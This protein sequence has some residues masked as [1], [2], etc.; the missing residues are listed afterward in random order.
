MELRWIKGRRMRAG[1]PGPPLIP[2]RAAAHVF[3]RADRRPAQ[4]PAGLGGVG[5]AGGDV[6]RA[7]RLDPAGHIPPAGL[8]EGAH[9]LQHAVAAPGTQIEGM[10]A[11]VAAQEAQGGGVAFGQ[12]H[13]VDVVPH[14]GPVGRGVVV[15]KDVQFG[16]QARSHLGDVGHQVVRHASGTFADQA[17][18]VRPHRIEV[19]Q[20][21]DAPGRIGGRQVAQDFLDVQ[22]AAAIRADGARG[23]ALVQGQVVRFAINGGAAAED[24]RARRRRAWPAA[25]TV[26]PGRCG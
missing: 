3:Q 25:G 1:L 16:P 7:A 20:A 14:A 22:L 4:I 13:D 21:G 24:Q 11:G 26:C 6:A 18:V 12:V 15:A 8:L 19:P 5:V 17:A 23:V 9:D 2:P 10:P